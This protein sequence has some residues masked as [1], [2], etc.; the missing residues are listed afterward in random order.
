MEDV[1]AQ[2]LGEGGDDFGVGGADI[3]YQSAHVFVRNGVG[4]GCADGVAYGALDVVGAD[5]VFLRDLRIDVLG[6]FMAGVVGGKAHQDGGSGVTAAARG[7]AGAAFR[8]EGGEESTCSP[9][10]AR[11]ALFG[12]GYL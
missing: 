7:P 1:C 11:G 5:V 2:F 6:Q 3:A 4:V 12:K 9:P 10:G 8:P